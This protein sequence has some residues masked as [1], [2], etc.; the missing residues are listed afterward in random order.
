MIGWAGWRQRLAERLR[1]LAWQRMLAVAAMIG[2]LGGMSTIG[3]RELILLTERWVYGSTSGSL[4]LIARSLTW[5]QRILV[6]A[7]GGLVAG[8]LLA[9]ARRQP[10]HDKGGDYME[11]VALGTGDLGARA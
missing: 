10:E 2:M 3:F 7:T 8:V 9:W 1:P 11:A 5:W 6:P 4:V